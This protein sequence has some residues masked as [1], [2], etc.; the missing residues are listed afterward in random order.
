MT[1]ILH[2]EPDGMK[3]ARTKCVQLVHDAI[4]QAP[5]F[6]LNFGDRTYSGAELIEELQNR[7]PIGDRVIQMW[8]RDEV[9]GLKKG[10]SSITGRIRAVI[11][12]I[13]GKIHV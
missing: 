1:D 3:I 8:L 6:G 11:A 13:K 5:G 4:R 7:T 9:Q 12:R 2:T 10:K